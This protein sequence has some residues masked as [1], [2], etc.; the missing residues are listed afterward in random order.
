MSPKFID[1]VLYFPYNHTS[2]RGC[3]SRSAGRSASH[4]D[5]RWTGKEGSLKIRYFA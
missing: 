1:S 5:W 2:L 3:T 4:G